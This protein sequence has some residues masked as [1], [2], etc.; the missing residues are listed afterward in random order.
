MSPTETAKV[1]AL[2]AAR[3]PQQRFEPG[4]TEAWYSDLQAVAFTD[5]VAAAKRCTAARP[6]VSLSELLAMVRVIGNERANAASTRELEA[7]RGTGVPLPRELFAVPDDKPKVVTDPTA[8]DHREAM[9]HLCKFCRAKPGQRCTVN[10]KDRA[11]PH[12][13]RGK[14]DQDT[15]PTGQKS[16]PASAS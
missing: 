11:T 6:F 5:A 1:C 12:P 2:I 10:G 8:L 16:Q 13:L 15:N 3:C 9:R 14:P 7:V 4:T